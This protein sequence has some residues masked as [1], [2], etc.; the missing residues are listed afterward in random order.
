[1]EQILNDSLYIIDLGEIN[2]AQEII[3]QLSS[4]LDK[5]EARNKRICL[6]LGNVDLNQA[7]LLSIKSLINGIDS[8]LSTVDTK[9]L[10][11]EKTAL[12]LGIIVSNVSAENSTEVAPAMPYKSVE[13]FKE[14]TLQKTEEE[15]FSIVEE[16]EP[17]VE[18]TIEAQPQRNEEVQSQEVE[19]QAQMTDNNENTE[20]TQNEVNVDFSNQNE[21]A[22]VEENNVEAKG[23]T[24]NENVI[25]VDNI[26]QETNNFNEGNVPV[27]EDVQDELDVIFGSNPAQSSIFEMKDSD[28]PK[29]ADREELTDII[30]PEQEYTKEDFELEAFPTK[31]I[32]QTIR[33]GQVIN[34]EG[35]I[36]IIGDCH[37]GS[38]ITAF[39]D[40]TVWGILSGIAHAG[41]GGNQKARVRALKMNAIQLRIANCYSRR[42]DSLNTV[43]IEKTNSFTPEEARIVNNEIVVFKIND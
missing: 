19:P 3:F 11:T 12:S 41:A 31:Y 38:E 36:V 33:S 1:M 39:G 37:P 22:S 10:E 18:T 17:T 27:K 15:Q 42:P 40:I 4:D 21:T 35:N 7:Q 25:N 16:A 34:Y 5:E 32:K 29:Y 30:V 13:E 8:T 43:Y 28:K 26:I 20:V 23:E 24:Q 14:E 9:S 6:K 2:T